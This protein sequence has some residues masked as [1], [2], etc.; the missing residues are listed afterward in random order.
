MHQGQI[1]AQGSGPGL[2]RADV[3]EGD[4][5]DAPNLDIEELIKRWP[6]KSR[7]LEDLLWV[8]KDFKRFRFVPQDLANS[9]KFHLLIN[10]ILPKAVEL[11]EK[12]LVFSQSI[13]SLDLLEIYLS[14]RK[15]G[16]EPRASSWSFCL[17]L[18]LVAQS[19]STLTA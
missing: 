13:P 17:S 5:E 1:D 7:D 19:L 8:E 12:V 11:G 16:S 10:A 2:P 18:L 14:R 3:S 4:F 9:F 6:L 15:V